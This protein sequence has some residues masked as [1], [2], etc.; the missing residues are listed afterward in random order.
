MRLGRVLS[1]TESSL[2]A[3]ASLVMNTWRIKSMKSKVFTIF[4]L[5]VLLVG[6][7]MV[8]ARGKEPA[9]KLATTP[10]VAATPTVAPRPTSQPTA[11]GDTPRP[12]PTQE[13]GNED[14]E[15]Q[16]RNAGPAGAPPLSNA[17]AYHRAELADTG[18]S[19]EVPDGWL[20]LESERAWTPG[21][22]SDLRLGVNWMDLKPP[23]EPEAAM[24]PSPSQTLFSE[25]VNLSWGQ[26]RRFL[27]EVYSADAQGN[28]AKAA[29]ESIQMHVLVVVPGQDM[30]RAFDLYVRGARLE[31]M[32]ALEPLLQRAL[33][34]SQLS[35]VG[36]EMVQQPPISSGTQHPDTGR[37]IVSD[38]TY[39]F[40][41]WVPQDWTWKELPVEGPGMPDDWPVTRI[42]HLFPQAWEADLNRSGPPDPNAKPVVAPVQV[43]VCVGPDDQFRRV[44]PE[45]TNS[46]QLEVNGLPVIVEREVF[47]PMWLARYVFQDPQNPEVRVVLIDYLRGF[48]DRVTGNEAL[49]ERVPEIVATFEFAR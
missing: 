40:R 18:L 41:L 8:S 19:F 36:E 1:Y 49:V 22:G 35:G 5:A 29:A 46:E 45:P 9:S 33:D 47:D 4:L 15:A 3:V 13:T 42:V 28:D 23:A 34:T 2:F 17:D 30:H 16:G 10:I 27:L 6:C 20:W 37:Q 12:L 31:D 7:T 32:G 11:A 26:G 21:E 24:L 43:E 38:E 48:P 14:E 39:G 44:Y 25:E